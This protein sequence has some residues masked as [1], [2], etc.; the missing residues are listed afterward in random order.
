[1]KA[2]EPSTPSTTGSRRSST[3]LQPL[4]PTRLF[5]LGAPSTSNSASASTQ[6]SRHASIIPSPGSVQIV[7]PCGNYSLP[8]L[9]EMEQCA[10]RSENHTP[11]ASTEPSV[12]R[13]TG[14][15]HDAM[16]PLMGPIDRAVQSFH[17]LR[18]TNDWEAPSLMPASVERREAESLI[19]DRDTPKAQASK[20]LL[21]GFQYASHFM[22]EAAI[23]R[24]SNHHHDSRLGDRNDAQFPSRIVNAPMQ[25]VQRTLMDHGTVIEAPYDVAPGALN[26]CSRWPNPNNY[27]PLIPRRPPYAHSEVSKSTDARFFPY[28]IELTLQV[29]P[30]FTE[31]RISSSQ[32]YFRPYE[33][34]HQ[35]GSA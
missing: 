20:S 19:R 27:S 21:P 10:E 1:M 22:D 3:Q 32:R 16:M 28:F 26:A 4:R 24:S 2:Q 33:S 34:V 5:Q 31:R 17:D 11:I 14:S 25:S 8:N 7:Q 18:L 13:V 29:G 23:A 35:A 15:T 30:R 9:R 12:Y 6:S